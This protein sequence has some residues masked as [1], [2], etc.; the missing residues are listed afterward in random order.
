MG[1]KRESDCLVIFVSILL[2][3]AQTNEEPCAPQEGEQLFEIWVGGVLCLLLTL[4]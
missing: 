2:F 4:G 1:E 3:G